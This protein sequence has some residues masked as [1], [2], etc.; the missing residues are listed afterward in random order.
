MIPKPFRQVILSE[1]LPVPRQLVIDPASDNHRFAKMAEELNHF[2]KRLP[3]PS[4][5]DPSA[6]PWSLEISLAPSPGEHQEA[7]ELKIEPGRI[8]L[9]AALPQALRNGIVT[10]KQV[11]FESTQKDGL[12]SLQSIQDHP[13]YLW[14]GLHLDVSRH[15]FELDFIKYYL[16]LMC[17]LKLNKF[18]WHLTDDQ[19]WRIESKRYPLLQ[20]IS[21]W[22]TEADGSK[23][24]G[25]YAQEQIHEIVA[26]AAELGIEVVPELDLP[27]H[28]MAVLAA[29]PDLACKPQAFETLNTWGISDD[30]LCAGKDS[31]IEFILDLV[32]EVSELFPGAYFHLGGDEAPKERWRE[33][34][35]CQKRIKELGL[36]NEENLQSWLFDTVS[37][38]LANKGKTVIGWDEILEGNPSRETIAMLWRGD[39]KDAAL[40]AEESG[41]K[42]ILVPNHYLYFDWKA[43]ESGPGAFGITTMEKVWQFPLEQYFTIRPQLLLGVQANLWTERIPSPERALQMLIPRVFA[44]AELAWGKTADYADFANRATLWEEYL[45]YALPQ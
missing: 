19:G 24:G 42:A 33:C 28:V 17:E 31:T 15:I 29:Y 22:R 16:R 32:D 10:L 9:K 13:R 26:Y 34:P 43:A 3:Y 4:R 41:Y 25:Y 39:G 8:S 27:G 30:I 2:L 20:E 1:R 40:R 21:A 18:H 38:A 45:D 37:T 7:Y 23:Y 5:S 12:I 44:L 14:R 11:L 36:Q 6:K 35:H